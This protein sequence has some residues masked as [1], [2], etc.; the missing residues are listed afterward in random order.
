M[1]AQYQRGD[2]EAAAR[3]ATAQAQGA[4]VKDEALYLLEE[5]AAI[6][7]W[8]LGEMTPTLSLMGASTEAFNAAEWRIDAYGR[9]PSIKVGSDLAA[10]FTNQEQLPYRGRAYDK[11]MLNTYKA[12]NYLQLEDFAAA[13]VELNRAL[14]R[15][16]EAV[17]ENA[18]RLQ[19]AETQLK[20]T[21]VAGAGSMRGVLGDSDIQSAFSGMQRELDAK[22]VQTYADYVNPFAVYL[23]G[24]FHLY[25]AADS[26]DI[27]RA[28]VSLE[29]VAGMQPANPYIDADLEAAERGHLDS[30]ITYVLFETGMGPI[31][32]S[33]RIQI[34]TF[35]FTNK[36]SF[37]G[38]AFPRLQYQGDYLNS[39]EVFTGENLALRTSVLADMDSVVSQDFKNEWPVIL[40][41]TLISMASKIALDATVQKQARDQYGWEGELLTKIATAALQ[42]A[43]NIADTRTWQTLPKQFQLARLPTPTNRLLRIRAGPTEKTLTIE[44]GAIN[45]VYVKSVSTQSPL[46][47]AQFTLK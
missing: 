47:I 12:L 45:V 10:N 23:D 33:E 8:A 11:V 20:Q 34:P 26:A 22:I 17:E 9:G 29:R 32:R 39:L 42:S 7:A 19:E 40:S 35:Y 37:I 1:V 5:G 6:R 28:R 25:Q 27:E 18:A 21:Q 14:V 15:Q 46:Q 4:K 36:V 16:R 38:M 13:R 2:F 30:G 24:L 43:I 41:R 31:R 3:S 44:P